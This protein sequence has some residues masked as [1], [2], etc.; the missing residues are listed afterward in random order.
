MATGLYY[1]AL[2]STGR[3][4]PGPF[5]CQFVVKLRQHFVGF[6]AFFSAS[7]I[8]GFE[9]GRCYVDGWHQHSGAV[10]GYLNLIVI[11]G[12]R[13]R[14]SYLLKLKARICLLSER[15]IIAKL[16]DAFNITTYF[17]AL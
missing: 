17:L 10:F 4:S 16:T 6:F 12:S 13:T 9:Q 3:I 2:P 11:R 8:F 15:Y 14:A 1:T 7:S 5:F